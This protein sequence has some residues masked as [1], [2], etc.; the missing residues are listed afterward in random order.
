[1][2]KC[3]RVSSSIEN[4]REKIDKR[5]GLKSYSF[6]VDFY[7]PTIFFG[8]YHWVDYLVFFSHQGR[9]T[10]FFCGGDITNLSKR[11]RL[12]KW[13]VR[14]TNVRYVCENDSE[15]YILHNIGIQAETLPQSFVNPDEF[16]VSYKHS[17]EPK[18]F[19]TYHKGRE[20]EYGYY[21]YPW[22]DWFCDLTEEE[23]NR[24]IKEYQGCI[25]LNKIDGFS[26]SLVKS[27]FVGQYQWSE[28]P[29]EGMSH[30]CSVYQ[31]YEDLKNK[32]E[33]NPLSEKYRA[34]LELNKHYL[35]YG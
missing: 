30:T 22:V 13:L 25:R 24:K 20:K 33:P 23:F 9:K 21:L 10:V 2:I 12:L 7:K 32:K 16:P 6:F 18:I 34:I 17:N 29:Y 5:Y 26:E 4:F 14:K 8:L 35:L 27:I 3:A 1:M 15:W 31:W 19:A 11:S 28:I